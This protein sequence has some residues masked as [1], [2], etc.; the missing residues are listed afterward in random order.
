MGV[1]YS[2]TSNGVHHCSFD[3]DLRVVYSRTSN[4]VYHC[5][6]HWGLLDCLLLKGHDLSMDLLP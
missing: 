1:V 2:H 4:H 6:F 5:S 3:W